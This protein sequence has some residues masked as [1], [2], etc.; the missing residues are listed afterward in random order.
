MRVAVAVV[1]VLC[2][3]AVGWILGAGIGATSDAAKFGAVSGGL[4]VALF[5]EG[6]PS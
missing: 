6:E 1:R 3:A 2:G 4:F 5:L